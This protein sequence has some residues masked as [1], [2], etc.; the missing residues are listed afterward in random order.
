MIHPDRSAAGDGDRGLGDGGILSRIL[1]LHE[2]I[3]QGNW[4][5]TAICEYGK[6]VF[7]SLSD[8]S[9]EMDVE[10]RSWELGDGK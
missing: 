5:G 9:K 10:V 3:V 8:H 4:M 6:R 2:V 7:A 1:G